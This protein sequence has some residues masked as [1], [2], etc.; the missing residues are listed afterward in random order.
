MSKFQTVHE[1]IINYIHVGYLD[2][3]SGNC[4]F[5]LDYYHGNQV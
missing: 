1:N 4:K 3:G 2:H 5:K